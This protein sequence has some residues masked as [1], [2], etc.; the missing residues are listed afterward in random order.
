MDGED[1]KGQRILDAYKEAIARI[2]GDGSLRRTLVSRLE[3]IIRAEG[4]PILV[5]KQ[6]HKPE[7]IPE[8]NE[9]I[10]NLIIDYKVMKADVEEYD[11]TNSRYNRGLVRRI[12]N[13]LCSA[14]IKTY[15][16]LAEALRK[17]VHIRNLGKKAQNLMLYHLDKISHT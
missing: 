2:V 9:E 12:D 16:D 15:G 14:G 1:L 13:S 10:S 6:E 5:N 3:K 8:I 4:F 7:H 17:K 11:P